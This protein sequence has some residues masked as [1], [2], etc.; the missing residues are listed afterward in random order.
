MG[1]RRGL[2]LRW[3]HRD[4]LAVLVVAVT[5]GFLTGMALLLVATGT[6]T[7]A[8]AAEYD[9]PGTA[10][11]YDSP[12]AAQAA[13]PEDAVVL[14]VAAVTTA[15][16]GNT[17]VVGVP[18]GETL[19]YGQ[20]TIRDG[21]GTTLGTITRPETR[22]LQGDARTVT[23]D[24]QPRG[25][26]HSIVPARW[27][28]TDRATVKELGPTGAY[29]IDRTAAPIP[30]QGVPLTAVLSFF[31]VGTRQA[32]Q[33]LGIVAI[34][35][36]LLVAVTVFS[37]SRMSVR[38]RLE[39]IRIVRATGGTPRD[40]LGL[41]TLRA[42]LLTAVGIGLGYAL[43]V[44]MANGVVSV[45]V[46]VGLPTSLA[47]SVTPRVLSLLVP[48][49]AGLLV[50]GALAGA[51]AAV[52]TIRLPPAHVTEFGQEA[53]PQAAETLL[54]RLRER[55]ALNLLDW[56]ALVPTVA[57]LTAF[58]VFVVLVTSMAAVAGPITASSDAT[59]TE[60]GSPHPV[61]SQVPGAYTDALRAQGINAS[62]EILLFEMRDGQPYPA[63][64]ANYT[65]F[66]SVTDI[67]LVE[68]R[69][70]RTT[71]EAVIGADLARTL[72]VAVGDTITMGGSTESAIDR[73]QVVGMFTAPGPYDDQLL[74]SLPTARH[75]SGRAG[76]AVQFVRT[77]HLPETAGNRSGGGIVGVEVMEPVVANESFRVQIH[78]RNDGLEQATT[79][80]RVTYRGQTRRVERTLPPSGAQTV[81]L[82]F[83]AGSAG[84][85]TLQAGNTTTN[86]T[87]LR[88]NAL[89]IRYLPARAPPESVPL[90]QV[91]TA[92]GR[93]LVD[94]TVT[95]GNRTVTTDADGRA[96]VPLKTVGT[97]TV[98]ATGGGRNAT[99][100]ISVD[101]NATRTLATRL[102]ITPDSPSLL[103]HP[104]VHLELTNP[105]N[106]TV[107]RTI[108]IQGPGGP[109]QQT[110][111]LTPGEQ[112]EVT[113]QLQRQP[114]GT[115]TVAVA[116]NG[117]QATEQK[118]V[119]TGDDRIVAALA[120]SGRTGTT[121]I[122]QAIEVAFGNLQLVLAALLALAGG[123]T[124]GGTT[125]TFAQ[126][127]HARRKTI[128]I[129]RAT[130]ADPQAILR[131]VIEDAVLV[132]AIAAILATCLGV[133]V[134][135]VLATVG[136]LT[137]Y[138]VRLSATPTA[139]VLLGI[140]GGAIA[141]TVIGAAFATIGL[142]CAQ[143]ARLLTRPDTQAGGGTDD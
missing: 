74:V 94:A 78:L 98:M 60:P 50:V 29:V 62:G 81:T 69:E 113:V 109:S 117:S 83:A 88:P 16:G 15:V 56:R 65:A 84:A 3:S 137:A 75:L 12:A 92:T 21:S 142:L 59:I 47:V 58:V 39:T 61:A 104:T 32:L 125:A 49:Y 43:G 7:T 34:G 129:H 87:V 143:P 135:H 127:V 42:A 114:P 138:G 18:D 6:Q 118:Y 24:V 107:T 38:D 11:Y 52:P 40:V 25:P 73:V 45:A 122:G 100:T 89:S 111:R 128:G 116:L 126:A 106:R 5:V 64:G 48:V 99:A 108:R 9:S 97:H 124:V 72:D 82:Q 66:A 67:E 85:Y 86:V 76:E 46:T 133:L 44:I 51:T 26:D 2:L 57:T 134:L 71:D 17:L 55:F 103:T 14:P 13:A 4:R 139:G 35:G 120:S 93:P 20:R 112:Q 68:G 79:R 101:R 96:W 1:Y 132:G 95:V 22:S 77:T 53:H 37:V 19:T 91:V 31:L 121:G 27:Y 140:L 110:I 8:I 130:G 28:A 23:V 141:L 36:G 136:Y 131:D 63:R 123:M 70:P 119:V 41:F 90:I 33:T 30:R 105:W 54:T 115:Y 102:R 10:T 80:T